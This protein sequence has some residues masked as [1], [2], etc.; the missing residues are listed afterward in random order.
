MNT[1]IQWFSY[2]PENIIK[3]QRF[4]LYIFIF[5]EILRSKTGNFF[6]LFFPSFFNYLSLFD[7]YVSNGQYL[8]YVCFLDS[9]IYR[10]R[11]IQI[12]LFLN[13]LAI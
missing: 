6:F 1:K 9:D 13:Y 10:K 4:R 5:N 3:E 11:L 12:Y 8:G 2:K 7:V